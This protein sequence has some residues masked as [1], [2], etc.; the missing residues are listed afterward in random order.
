MLR[1]PLC[2]TERKFLDDASLG[3]CIPWTMFPLFHT[4]THI[5]Y[6]SCAGGIPF[7][8]CKRRWHLNWSPTQFLYDRV[9]GAQWVGME[10]G[11][12][13]FQTRRYD[14]YCTLYIVDI[15]LW[16][17]NPARQGISSSVYTWSLDEVRKE[18]AANTIWRQ[19]LSTVIRG[20]MISLGRGDAGQQISLIDISIRK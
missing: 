6:P 14:I 3:R 2:V 15:R 18:G 9:A 4:H 17:L 7:R 11:I 12:C 8:L 19:Q 10:Y 20:A 5:H 16:A 1:C 13:R